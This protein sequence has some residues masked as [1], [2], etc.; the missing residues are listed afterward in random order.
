M[1]RSFLTLTLAA[2][3]FAPTYGAASPATS[4]ANAVSRSVQSLT[5]APRDIAWSPRDLAPT[6]AYSPR[7]DDED[8]NEDDNDEDEGTPPAP[9]IIFQDQDNDD[10]SSDRDDETIDE[11][12][13]D[14]DGAGAG[15]IAGGIVGG[16]L[17]LL[18]LLSIWYWI[19]IRP[20][21]RER[22]RR[23]NPGALKDEEDLASHIAV[24]LRRDVGGQGVGKNHALSS[25]P[26]ATPRSPVQQQGQGDPGSRSGLEPGSGLGGGVTAPVQTATSTGQVAPGQTYS[27]S[28][29]STLTP[30]SSP[31]PIPGPNAPSAPSPASAYPRDEKIPTART[32]AAPPEYKE[33]AAGSINPQLPLPPIM[34]PAWKLDSFPPAQ[35]QW[36]R[37]DHH[38]HHHGPPLREQQHMARY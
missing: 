15:T 12:D 18:L 14:N 24:D 28:S 10:H 29:P 37:E 26:A 27:S 19:V 25:Y 7:N 21:R 9:D 23:E 32:P 16:L 22:L 11:L 1:R 38:H 30:M 8:E 2:S 36:N 34:V 13:D 4:H 17:A 20:R 33:E 3:A 6:S 5:H 35:P 31:I